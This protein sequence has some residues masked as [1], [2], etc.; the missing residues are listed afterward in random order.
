MSEP[1]DF[2]D[3]KVNTR[4]WQSN[5]TGLN[6]NVMLIRELLCLYVMQNT[7]PISLI[8]TGSSALSNF[9]ACFKISSVEHIY[10]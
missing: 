4:V 5:G 9:E 1:L 2:H 10:F 6:A 3:Y 8:E 7:P